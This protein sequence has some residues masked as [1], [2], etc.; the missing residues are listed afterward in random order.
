MMFSSVMGEE[1]AESGGIG[2]AQFIYRALKDQDTAK[3][4]ALME[5]ISGPQ[6]MDKPG[7]SEM[8]ESENE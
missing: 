7:F 4:N 2:L 5:K 6:I 8:W 3:L 1:M